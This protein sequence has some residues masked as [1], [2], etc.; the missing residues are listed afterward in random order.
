MSAYIIY[1]YNITD[2]SKID[3]LT[4]LSQPINE[5]Y[6][7]KVLVGSP[8]KAVEGNT[9]SSIVV[10]EFES[11][12][13]AQVFQNADEQK[14]LSLLRNE[15]TDGWSAIVPGATETQAVIDSGYFN[16]KP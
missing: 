2:R 16:V 11:F 4:R 14:E 10:L 12:A 7:A 13:A 6:G 1:H 15:I 3:E 8:V 9:Y 5:K